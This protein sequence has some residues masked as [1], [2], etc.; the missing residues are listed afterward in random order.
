MSNDNTPMIMTIRDFLDVI[1]QQKLPLDTKIYLSSDEEG[2]SYYGLAEF[3]IQGKA[4]YFVLYPGNSSD[5]ELDLIS[6]IDKEMQAE[7]ELKK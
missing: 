1:K 3:G 4:K 7:Y 2:N 5:F 6:E